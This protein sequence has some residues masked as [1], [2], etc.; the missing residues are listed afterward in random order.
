MKYTYVYMINNLH[1]T[2]FRLLQYHMYNNIDHIF[3]YILLYL[4]Y[5]M[6]MEKEK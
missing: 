3:I 6:D 5:Y 4:D 1:S 2:I